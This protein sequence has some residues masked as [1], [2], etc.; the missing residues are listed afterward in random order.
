MKMANN[1]ASNAKQSN[2][3]TVAGGL[4]VEH[5]F[6]SCLMHVVNCCIHSNKECN[7]IAAI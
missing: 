1:R 5:S 6:H 4:N 2:S 3:T 7:D